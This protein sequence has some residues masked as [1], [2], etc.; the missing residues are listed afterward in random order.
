[1]QPLGDVDIIVDLGHETAEIQAVV[2][3]VGLVVGK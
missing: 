2:Q 1:M 3:A